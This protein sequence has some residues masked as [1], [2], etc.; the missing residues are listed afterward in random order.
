MKKDRAIQIILF[1]ILFGMF[2]CSSEFEQKDS[3]SQVDSTRM[4]LQSGSSLVNTNDSSKRQ[5]NKLRDMYIQAISDYIMAT[6]NQV[7]LAYDTLIFG[8]HV[9]GQEDD[10]PDIELPN[11]INH[12]AIKLVDPELGAQLQEEKKSRVY[13]NLVGFVDSAKAEFIFVTFSNGMNHQFDCFINYTNQQE[14]EGIKLK[15]IWLE[16]YR[17][18]QA[19]K[20]KRI[21]IYQDGKF[22]KNK[23]LN[24]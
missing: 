19:G 4:K 2:A 11:E 17:L 1:S 20:N 12:I 15:E 18:N 7:N 10:F 5:L 14:A 13:I 6:N 22:V 21:T 24:E 9:Y 3:G 23:P 8:K 16:D